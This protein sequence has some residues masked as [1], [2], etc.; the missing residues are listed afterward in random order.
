MELVVNLRERHLVLD[1]PPLYGKVGFSREKDGINKRA[2][3]AFFY[4]EKTIRLARAIG[5][6]MRAQRC[7]PRVAIYKNTVQMIA[8]VNPIPEDSRAALSKLA[9][10]RLVRKCEE[11]SLTSVA[12]F[13]SEELPTFQKLFREQEIFALEIYGPR[14]EELKAFE[15]FLVS[16]LEKAEMQV[17]L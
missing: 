12:S 1:M 16:S 14:G 3:I 2:N 15:T 6:G 11:F 17:V 7:L 8:S 10:P 13:V 4:D 9:I 5:R